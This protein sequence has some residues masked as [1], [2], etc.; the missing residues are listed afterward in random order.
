MTIKSLTLFPLLTFT[1]GLTS[2]FFDPLALAERNSFGTNT[3]RE[4][5]THCIWKRG[6]I[7]LKYRSCAAQY[8]VCSQFTRY[9]KPPAQPQKCGNWNNRF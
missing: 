1:F 8:R 3:W 5:R 6:K 7:G 2:Y 4:Y 9:G